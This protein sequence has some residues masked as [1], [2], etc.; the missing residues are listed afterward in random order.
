MPLMPIAKVLPGYKPQA[1]DTS[2][3]ADV[4]MFQ[5]LRQFSSTQKTQ[6]FQSF[7]QSVRRMA[8]L[9]IKKQFPNAST[10]EHIQEYVKQKLLSLTGAIAVDKLPKLPEKSMILDPISLAE[11]ISKIL[12]RLAIPYM[13]GGSV[14]SSLLGEE[15]STQDLDLVIDIQPFNLSPFVAAMSEEFYI[16]AGAVSEAIDRKSSFNAIHLLSL[17]KVDFFVL[18]YDDFSLSKFSRRQLYTIADEPKNEIY[19]YSPEDIVL[20]KLSWYK[21]GR[22]QSQKQWRDVLGVL[23]LQGSQLDFAYLK[24]WAEFLKLTS[25]L[26]QA[27]R[28]SGLE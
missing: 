7:N 27:L 4:L 15:R 2:I 24:Q 11:K 8:L 1:E 26:T 6:R 3:D 20:Q 28:E 17:E 18:P 19:I 12:L 22:M 14:A 13:V 21:M 25:L 9:R 10:A 5:L 16:D 23:K